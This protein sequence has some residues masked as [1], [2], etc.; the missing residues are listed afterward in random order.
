MNGLH[1][2]RYPSGRYGFVGRVPDVLA[3]DGAPE[4]LE[5]ARLSGPRIAQRIAERE[6]RT[7]RELTWDSEQ[8]ARDAA[9]KAGYVIP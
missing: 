5:T 4:D 6:G 1:I 7:F 2:I 8:D 3:Y 9:A